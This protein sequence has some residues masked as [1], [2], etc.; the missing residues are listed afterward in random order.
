MPEAYKDAAE[1]VEALRQ[2]GIALPVAR[3]RPLG[4]VKG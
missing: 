4:V 2:S 1:V 3:L